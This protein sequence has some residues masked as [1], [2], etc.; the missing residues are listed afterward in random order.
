MEEIFLT[1]AGYLVEPFTGITL[2]HQTQPC[3]G[4]NSL[5]LALFFIK[6]LVEWTLVDQGT[7]F[8]NCSIAGTFCGIQPLTHPTGDLTLG[9]CHGLATAVQPVLIEAVFTGPLRAYDIL[10]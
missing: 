10:G 1:L 2:L 9:L 6:V 7:V 4:N 5:T 3:T 8:L